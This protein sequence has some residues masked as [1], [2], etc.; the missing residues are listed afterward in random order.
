MA[1]KLGGLAVGQ[2]N[3]HIKLSRIFLSKI[4]N[5]F[6][7]SLDM[8]RQSVFIINRLQ[9]KRKLVSSGLDYSS[10]F[11]QL[12]PRRSPSDRDTSAVVD[13]MSL[14]VTVNCQLHLQHILS[15]V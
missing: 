10:T 13:M 1:R 3:C 2:A 11:V 15:S 7:K 9:G 14:Y 12:C 8:K 4:S 5:Q 6:P